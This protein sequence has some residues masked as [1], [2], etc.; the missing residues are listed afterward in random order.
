[1]HCFWRSCLQTETVHWILCNPGRRIGFC[2]TQISV[3]PCRVWAQEPSACSRMLDVHTLTREP[4]AWTKYAV[5]LPHYAQCGK[6]RLYCTRTSMHSQDARRLLAIRNCTS[7][8]PHRRVRAQASVAHA[9]AHLPVGCGV[10]MKCTRSAAC[11]AVAFSTT[12]CL[13][14]TFRIHRLPLPA[15]GIEQPKKGHSLAL[16]SALTASHQSEPSGSDGSPARAGRLVSVLVAAQLGLGG[17]ASSRPAEPAPVW[18]AAA[19]AGRMLWADT[20]AGASRRRRHR[21][22]WGYHA[23]RLAVCAARGSCAAP[24][25]AALAK[26]PELG[27]G[28]RCLCNCQTPE[29][30]SPE[31]EVRE[32]APHT[33]S[34]RDHFEG[35]D[36]GQALKQDRLV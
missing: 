6:N 27:L 1:M 19:V 9:Q 10:A 35:L 13:E 17:L 16:R 25:A 31:N 12:L 11:F 7:E 34:L 24:A 5:R 3:P 26:G 14:I 22:R 36:S 20:A 32:A 28:I 29:N 33:G 4:H 23:S 21:R 18:H 8:T 30:D 2:R 15:L